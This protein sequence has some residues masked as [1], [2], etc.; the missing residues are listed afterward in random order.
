MNPTEDCALAVEA[1]TLAAEVASS[2]LSWSRDALR[3][4]SKGTPGDVVTRA[5]IAAEHAVRDLLLA[6]RAADGI[7]GEEGTTRAGDRRW[8]VDAI[9]GTLNFVRGDPFWCSAVALE[10]DD[11]GLAAAVHHPASGGTFSASRG[12]GCWLNGQ[13]LTMAAGP[14]LDHAILATY[15]DPGDAS[16][17]VLQRVV[18]QAASTR[19]RGSGTLELAW[20][21][22]GR[23]DLWLQRDVFAWDWAP[24]ALLVREAGGRAGEKRVGT[25]RWSYASGTATHDDLLAAIR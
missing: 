18:G 22:A 12:G 11:G 25:D 3:V 2:F 23:V 10:D 15:L 24:G 20:L 5:D 7:L 1:A 14:A 8:L 9:D 6:R 4:T 16:A 19:A 21:A 13:R 17:A